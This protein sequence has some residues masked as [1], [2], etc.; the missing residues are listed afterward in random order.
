[1]QRKCPECRKPRPPTGGAF[2]SF[3][4]ERVYFLGRSE[5]FEI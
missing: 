3:G 1:M 4:C 5:E 2:C